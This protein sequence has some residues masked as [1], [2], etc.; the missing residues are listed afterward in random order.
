MKPRSS[1]RAHSLGWHAVE[2]KSGDTVLLA[3]S[4]GKFHIMKGLELDP[5][6]YAKQCVAEIRKHTDREIIYRPKPS[7]RDAVPIKGA[8]FSR[9]TSTIEQ[10]LAKAHCLVTYGSNACFEAVRAGVPSIILGDAVARGISSNDLV[11]IERPRLADAKT[12]QQFLNN[13]AWFQWSTEEF[14]N[15]KA[16]GFI[17][18]QV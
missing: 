3:G 14:K 7:W 6:E 13:L 5:T 17:S 1:E 15:G 2:W 11:D 9:G 16:W 18:K 4:S 10:D 12:V 8:T